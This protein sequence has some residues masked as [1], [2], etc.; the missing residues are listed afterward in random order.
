MRSKKPMYG[1][2]DAPL[3]FQLA[4]LYYFVTTCKA[5][6]SHFDVNFLYI[7]GRGL[8]HRAKSIVDL[9]DNSGHKI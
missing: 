6:T 2:G 7:F 5:I 4:L 8:E 3:M 9:R 1:F